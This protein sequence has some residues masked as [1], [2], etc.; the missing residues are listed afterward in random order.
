MAHDITDALDLL[1]LAI[2]RSTEIVDPELLGA[3][4]E[5]GAATRKRLGFLGRSV[6]VALVGGTGSG[7]SSLLNALAGE[8]VAPTGAV[9]PTTERPLAWI[10]ANPEPGLV[11]LLD[12][13]AI[14]DRVG[15]DSFGDLAVLDL[16]D[17]DSV[18]RSHRRMVESLLP[19]VDAVI[20][21]LDPEKYNDRLLHRELLQPLGRYSSQFIFVLNQI[22]RLSPA[23]ERQVIDDLH[24]TL[25]A[26]GILDPLVLATAAAPVEG[27]P[28]GIARLSRDL[29][30][31]FEAKQAVMTKVIA[32]LREARD[33]VVEATG[34]G[35]GEGT[36]YDVRWEAAADEVTGKLL[37]PMSGF[38]PSA[39]AAGRNAALVKGGGPLAALAGWYRSSRLSRVAGL[40]DHAA[41]VRLD[42]SSRVTGAA[43]AITDLVADLSFEIGGSFGRLLRSEV[44]SEQVETEIERVTTIA[45][46]EVGGF[47]VTLNGAWWR[48]IGILQWLLAGVVVAGA[49]WFWTSP[50]SLQP[51]EDV[52]P[53][54]MIVAGLLSSII[55]RSLVVAA[56]RRAGRKA[57]HQYSEALRSALRPRIDR[58]I[59][60]PIRARMRSR[61]EVAGAL[62][63]LGIVTAELEERLIA[64]KL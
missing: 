52:R 46:R 49:L 57:L 34:I 63:E 47:E 28:I 14:S 53:V 4:A 48:V 38:E 37:D 60:A 12:D 56:G 25:A 40:S 9:R 30:G 10:P 17:T 51:G 1:D 19:R 26:D 3:S 58:T 24:R 18:L 35:L 36:S 32:D 61:A 16:P 5:L 45:S 27:S 64:G 55:L 42:A 44:Q 6:V 8:E 41:E 33:G 23:E 50:E 20:W 7:K 31:R 54:V 62:A 59:G 13:L 29:H 39:L 11:R 2:G 43:A 15:H 22:D 21:V